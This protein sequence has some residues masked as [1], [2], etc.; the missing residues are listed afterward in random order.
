MSM[1]LGIKP[2]TLCVLDKHSTLSYNLS[3]VCSARIGTC[4]CTCMLVHVVYQMLSTC[5][6]CGR[7]S[8]LNPVAGLTRLASIS[9][10]SISICLPNAAT[11]GMGHPRHFCLFDKKFCYVAQWCGFELLNSRD[12]PTLASQA[13]G[14]RA[15]MSCLFVFLT[16]CMTCTCGSHCISV[17]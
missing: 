1:V 12:P 15:C 17:G 9:Q 13:L 7:A 4:M 11:K 2:R 10:R 16:V 5:S 6:F 8:S 14:L 3:P